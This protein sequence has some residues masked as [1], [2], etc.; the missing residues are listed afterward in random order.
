MS[1]RA[2][3]DNGAWVGFCDVS[4]TNAGKV[5]AVSL[6]TQSVVG[7]WVFTTM[8][9]AARDPCQSQMVACVRQ[10]GFARDMARAFSA[11]EG[12]DFGDVFGG[13]CAM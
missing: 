10:H 2:D 8:R 6:P 5:V 9:S 13:P 12:N 1:G 3:F 11:E 4:A 7:L